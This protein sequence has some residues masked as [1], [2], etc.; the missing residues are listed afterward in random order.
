M[1][2]TALILFALVAAALAAEGSHARHGENFTCITC[3]V[4]EGVGGR[5]AS[6][7]SLVWTSSTTR[8]GASS[9]ISTA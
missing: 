5:A 7:S 8:A 3:H 9:T 1:L 4:G 6:C 2:R